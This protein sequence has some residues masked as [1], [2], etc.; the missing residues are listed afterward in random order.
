MEGS[1]FTILPSSECG[2]NLGVLCDYTRDGQGQPVLT[3]WRQTCELDLSLVNI[4]SHLS[5]L[6][7]CRNDR[8]EEDYEQVTRRA[9]SD[10]RRMAATARWDK[11]REKQQNDQFRSA[12]MVQKRQS[13]RPARCDAATQTSISWLHG[14]HIENQGETT[15]SILGAIFIDEIIGNQLRKCPRYSDVFYE[16]SALLYLSSPKAYRVMRQIVVL[17]ATASLYRVFHETFQ[18]TTERLLDLHHVWQSIGDVCDA[19]NNLRGSGK[20]V[21]PACTLG[22]DAFCFR[23]FSGA[24]VETSPRQP[25]VT[26][27]ANEIA[28]DGEKTVAVDEG[29]TKF[30]YGFLFLLIPHDY[31]VPI[32][33]LHLYA[34]ETGSYNAEIAAKAEQIRQAATSS[35]LRIWCRATDRDPGVSREHSEFYSAHIRGKSAHFQKLVEAVYAWLCKDKDRW[36]PISDPLHVFKNLRARL[37][38][39]PIKIFSN[40]PATSLER[41]RAVL[42]LGGALNDETQTGKMRDSYVVALFTFDNVVKLL[43]SKCYVEACLLLPFAC[44]AAVIFSRDI[45][46]KLRSFLVEFAFQTIMAF[47]QELVAL[48]VSGT[49]SRGAVNNVTTFSDAHYASRMLNTLVVFGVTLR[50][51]CENVRMDA[52]GTHLVENC[53]GIARASSSDPRYE[54]II[55]TYAHAEI[56]KEIAAKI[57]ITLYVPGR[58][59]HGGCKVDPDYQNTKERL[60]RKPKEW[61]VDRLLMLIRGICQ[62]ETCKFMTE[63]LERFILDLKALVPA[64]DEHEYNINEAANCGIMARIVSFKKEK[65]QGSTADPRPGDVNCGDPET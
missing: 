11:K 35:G 6:L 42:D 47:N 29:K 56:R 8:Q 38:A 54:R 46:L 20:Q 23:S 49:P 45:K 52:L 7:G 63:D 21:N 30:S 37:L 24:T 34:A 55:Q 16:M 44:W 62:K 19:I 10:K 48:S 60:I 33:I 41:M 36:I 58:V 65:R 15:T 43:K 18:R 22:I 61:R 25:S 40:C 17:P 31:R 13:Q 50:F 12:Y 59:N 5:F 64:L 4:P 1:R 9:I 32:K 27:I 28:A 57:G 3:L 53:I 2:Y 51:G 14:V 26:E 39:H